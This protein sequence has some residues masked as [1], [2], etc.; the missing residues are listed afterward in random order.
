MVR[1]FKLGSAKGNTHNR[2]PIE[3][4]FDEETDEYIRV[5]LQEYHDNLHR[6]A[7][8]ITKSISDVFSNESPNLHDTEATLL[9]Y[10]EQDPDSS[11]LTVMN[12]EYGSRH[13]TGKPL[14][15]SYTDTSLVTIVLVDGGDCA[16]FQHELV[17]GKWESVRLPKLIPNDPVFMVYAGESLQR[18]SGGRI[19]SKSRRIVP[20]LGHQTVNGLM[21]SLMPSQTVE[22]L[23]LNR[24]LKNC[25]WEEEVRSPISRLTSELNEIDEFFQSYAFLEE[26]DLQRNFVSDRREELFMMSEKPIDATGDPF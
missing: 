13:D 21:F 24:E 8:S 26:E 18:L 19:P 3:G 16:N 20:S 6:V 9:S 7:V 15:T 1:K 17:E 2:W 25:K 12:C 11:L 10:N 14:I 23:S 5:S 22:S 4:T